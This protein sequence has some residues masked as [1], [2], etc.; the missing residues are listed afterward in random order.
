MKIVKMHEAKSQLS[1]LVKDSV[2]GIDVFLAS[3]NT[4]MVQLVPTKTKRTPGYLKGKIK[5]ADDFDAPLPDEILDDFGVN[6]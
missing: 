5:V 6:G 4:V 3:G 2:N 1:K